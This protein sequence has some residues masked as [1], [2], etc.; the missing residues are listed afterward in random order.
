MS[1]VLWISKHDFIKQ[2]TSLQCTIK[3]S[4]HQIIEICIFNKLN[5]VYF[6]QIY[7]SLIAESLLNPS[8]NKLVLSNKDK[9]SYSKKLLMAAYGLHSVS[10]SHSFDLQI[11]HTNNVIHV[12]MPSLV[13]VDN[14]LKV[15][16]VWILIK[17][18][19][20]LMLLGFDVHEC[21]HECRMYQAGY[22]FNFFRSHD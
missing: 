15:D 14:F 22:H 8:W 5:L 2:Q 12:A 19:S 6:I 9:V 16:N 3:N 7:F 18:T 4:L 20:S 1:N 17:H 11:W 21:N 13:R 10:G